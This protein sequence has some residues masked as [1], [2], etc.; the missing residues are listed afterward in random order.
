M[1]SSKFTSYPDNELD[2]A[3]HPLKETSGDSFAGDDLKTTDGWNVMRFVD[4]GNV[5]AVGA[6]SFMREKEFGFRPR[7]AG[8]V[9][10]QVN[11]RH[12]KDPGKKKNSSGRPD[13]PTGFSAGEL[14]FGIP[15]NAAEDE[16][17]PEN[18]DVPADEVGFEF[19]IVSDYYGKMRE[20]P[21]W[22]PSSMDSPNRSGLVISRRELEDEDKNFDFP[23]RYFSR[24]NDIFV[25]QATQ[26]VKLKRNRFGGGGGT[27]PSNVGGSFADSSLAA[28]DVQVDDLAAALGDTGELG[29]GDDGNGDGK[30]GGFFSRTPA[31]EEYQDGLWK[32]HINITPWEQPIDAVIDQ[33]N[34]HEG[35]PGEHGFG[36]HRY[37]PGYPSTEIEDEPSTDY[38]FQ[39]G[40][41][42]DGYQDFMGQIHDIIG[43]DAR[44]C[45]DAS[46]PRW[47]N[48]F[49]QPVG[50]TYIRHDA[51]FQKAGDNKCVPVGSRMSGRIYFTEPVQCPN[52]GAKTPTAGF[53]STVVLGGSPAAV[54]T[55]S[56][57]KQE[58]AATSTPICGEMIFDINLKDHETRIGHECGEWRPMIMSTGPGG[59][60]SDITSFS[61]HH[62]PGGYSGS[63]GGS[64]GAPA[65]TPGRYDGTRPPS[66]SNRPPMPPPPRHTP[67]Q[68]REFGTYIWDSINNRWV[69]VPNPERP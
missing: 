23:R 36:C 44:E 28:T 69:W 45:A 40:W 24:V 41:L 27:A 59:G 4:I 13:T 8:A 16:S 32:T 1:G 50:I 46:L 43:L 56:A 26:D 9:V 42:Y 64:S 17:D 61:W 52:I 66:G 65:P 49:K 57:K 38:C 25:P 12:F 63:G 15:T 14:E 5:D 55:E 35:G 11:Y 54:A 48:R 6:R 2:A 30:K 18:W 68:L 21:S 33:K 22:G 58:A 20:Y 10:D 47:R 34:E 19:S 39:G 62:N 53:P 67:G 31:E 29:M 3:L 60:G 37:V 7:F 51:H